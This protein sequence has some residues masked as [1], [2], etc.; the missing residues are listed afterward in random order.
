MLSSPILLC[1]KRFVKTKIK[2]KKEFNVKC[3]P[4]RL[5][6]NDTTPEKL[7]DLMDTQNGCITVTSAEGGI[8]DTM[9]GRYDNKGGLDMYLDAHA[10]DSIMVDRISRK[11]NCVQDP[12]LTMMLTA[13][14]EVLNGL[15][16]SSTFRGRGLCGRFLYAIC[17][18]QVGRREVAPQTVSS[19]VKSN[20]REFVRR[21][22]DDNST[23]VIKLSPEA[24]SIRKEYQATVEKRLANE[25]EDIKDWGGKLTGAAMRIAGLLHAAKVDGNPAAVPVEPDTVAAATEIA[26][27]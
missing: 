11:G 23:G 16:S 14:P 13:Q 10:G 22:L 21:I 3:Y 12:R 7:V 26:E 2:R 24:D 1:N 15:M 6:C 17:K 25:W 27:F 8:F 4:F 9:Q 5:L 19:T 20:Y 18:S